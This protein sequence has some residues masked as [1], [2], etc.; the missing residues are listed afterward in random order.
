[1][2][3]GGAICLM[4]VWGVVHW[5]IVSITHPVFIQLSSVGPSR[6]VWA[7]DMGFLVKSGVLNVQLWQVPVRKVISFEPGVFPV[8]WWRHFITVSVCL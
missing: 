4:E 1:M 7:S 5:D 8:H 6:D 3:P 2:V